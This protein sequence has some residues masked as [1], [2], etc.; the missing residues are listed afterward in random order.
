MFYLDEAW[1]GVNQSFDYLLSFGRS[2]KTSF[3]LATQSIHQFE[4]V[5]ELKLIM[6]LC[7]TKV[8][9][10]AGGDDEA[11][12]LASVYGLPATAFISLEKYQAWARIFNRN[13]LIKT[14][15]FP[16][17]NDQSL[18]FKPGGQAVYQDDPQPTPE[19]K[20]SFLKECWFSC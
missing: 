14:Y 4:S 17:L 7:N 3:N 6:S 19:V 13:S 12:L 15:P 11:K 16:E 20:T 1:M 9:L 5:K 18:P 8:A 2:F 10:L